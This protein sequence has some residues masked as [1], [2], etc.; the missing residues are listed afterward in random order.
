MDRTLQDIMQSEELFGGKVVCLA[1]DP[2]Q[3]LPVVKRGGR[4]AIVN[5]C[6]QMSPIFPQLKQCFLTENM[7]ADKEEKA[8]SEYLLSL[9]EGQEDTYEELGDFAIK[10]PDEY[11]VETKEE[12]I[13]KVFPNLGR[14]NSKQADL[15]D[16]SIYTP[17]NVQAKEINDLCLKDICGDSRTYLSADSILEDD[18]KEVVP[19]EYLNTITISGMADHVLCLKIGSPVILLRNL[20][21]DFS[22]F[23][24]FCLYIHYNSFQVVPEAVF[25]TEHG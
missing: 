23:T 21:G 12:L 15:I 1:G 9:G 5:A 8:F 20:Q 3:T 18:H 14:P 19:S 2:R 25:E 6:L 11:L 13:K 17:L 22:F 24:V 16:G 10:I 7:R 4:A